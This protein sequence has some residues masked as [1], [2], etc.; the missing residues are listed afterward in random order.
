MTLRPR[1][2]TS[3]NLKAIAR[4]TLMGIGARLALEGDR[5][6]APCVLGATHQEDSHMNINRPSRRASQ[7]ALSCA[8]WAILAVGL[9]ACSA[10]YTSG[11]TYASI[12]VGTAYGPY[13]YP[14]NYGSYSVVSYP[15]W[16][17]PPPPPEN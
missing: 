17:D 9:G 6:L 10:G 3:S 8:A 11:G 14:Y 12:G 13:W 5:A 16:G 1:P 7:L 4:T 15:W 2:R